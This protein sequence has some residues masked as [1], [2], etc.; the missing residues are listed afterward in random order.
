MLMA[1]SGARRALSKPRGAL[2]PHCGCTEEVSICRRTRSLEYLV[3]K[4]FKVTVLRSGVFCHLLWRAHSVRLRVGVLLF[5]ML[6]LFSLYGHAVQ[7]DYKSTDLFELMMN[8]GN[9]GVRTRSSDLEADC[10]PLV[11]S[12]RHQSALSR[13]GKFLAHSALIR[14]IREAAL[15]NSTF[16]ET[17]VA[18][19]RDMIPAKASYGL[20]FRRNSSLSFLRQH[21][22][23]IGVIG[24]Y[25]KHLVWIRRS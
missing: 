25:R 3:R 9:D 18:L 7:F 22:S 14:S 5:V 1:T 17:G 16:F 20:Q 4:F 21:A 11:M 12:V 8:E 6:H 23:G 19:K 13:S 10:L 2:P 24:N 15:A